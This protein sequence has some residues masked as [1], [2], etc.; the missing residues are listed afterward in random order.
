MSQVSVSGEGRQQRL[1]IYK[2]LLILLYTIALLIGTHSPDDSFAVETAI[3]WAGNDK[4]A[5]FLG[6]F[7]LATLIFTAGVIPRTWIG[8]TSTLAGLALLGAADELTQ[9]CFDRSAEWSDWLF[10]MA[11]IGLGLVIG[12]LVNRCWQGCCETLD[13][14]YAP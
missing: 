14:R 4:L 6:Y 7:G 13:R 9:P 3:R 12:T 10:D 5:H 8:M 1:V 2:W 11:G